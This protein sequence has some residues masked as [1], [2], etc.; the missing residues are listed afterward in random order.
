MK[1]LDYSNQIVLIV[2][3]AIFVD[4]L[5][6]SVVLPFLPFV[7]ERLKQSPIMTGIILAQY[8]IGLVISS[9]VFGI[10]SD[11]LDKKKSLM[12][13]GL[14][15]MI[16]AS[17]FM[18]FFENLWVIAIGRFAQ[19]VSSG[20]TWVSGL[21][22]LGASNDSESIGTKMG[23]VMASY[24]LGQ[25]LGPLIGGYFF[26]FG[27]SIPFLI[28]TGGA[29]LDLVMRMLLV[30]PTNSTI[31]TET[32]IISGLLFV[33][34]SRKAI[35]VLLLG[36]VGAFVIGSLELGIVLLLKEHF[37]LQEDKVGLFFMVFVIPQLIVSFFGGWLYDKV[38]FRWT[39]APSAI[40]CTITLGLMSLIDS[41]FVFACMVALFSISLTIFMA[42]MLPELT[43]AVPQDVYGA[44]FGVFNFV[45][46]IGLLF[47][48]L[49]CSLMY[50]YTSWAAYCISL[51]AL[52]IL[53]FPIILIKS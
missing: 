9:L 47:G 37:L 24:G 26:Q 31:K 45:F 46:G 23:F 4:I 48:P 17:L 21:G 8:S 1:S 7:V 38:G 20:I 28:I 15:L 32:S 6:Y 52:Y 29:A 25:F 12:I 3:I 41:I 30:E 14:V 40:F 44:T 34:K 16:V 51:A 36:T 5:S 2:S 39:C 42:A 43:K 10:I 49:F 53:T 33:F 50:Q 19:G 22:L 11:R 35:I 13:F 27:Y 18:A